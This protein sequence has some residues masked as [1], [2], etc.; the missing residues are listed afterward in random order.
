MRKVVESTLVSADGV[1]G[2]PHTWTGEHCGEEAVTRSLEQMHRTDAM[3]MGRETVFALVE[4][5]N[6]AC[7]KKSTDAADRWC[8]STAQFR[9]RAALLPADPGPVLARS[10]RPQSFRSIRGDDDPC[11]LTAC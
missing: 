5:P 7:T 2:E 1:I 11:R 3:V 6:L 8:F 10:R 9:Q 4:G